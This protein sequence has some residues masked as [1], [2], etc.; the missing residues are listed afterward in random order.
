[1]PHGSYH[2]GGPQL[3]APSLIGCLALLISSL[4]K[5]AESLYVS[6]PWNGRAG[7]PAIGDGFIISNA[8]YVSVMQ[9]HSIAK[10]AFD[11][12]KHFI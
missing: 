6:P 1:M 9:W 11:T 12:I 3:L 10:P 7:V 2:L 4:F 8:E 5:A